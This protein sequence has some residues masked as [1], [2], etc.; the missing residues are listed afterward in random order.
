MR[1]MNSQRRHNSSTRIALPHSR[2]LIE[3]SAV[4]A[5]WFF[6]FFCFDFFFFFF[7]VGYTL[8]F[9]PENREG[10]KLVSNNKKKTLTRILR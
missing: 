6:F 10:D 4:T 3:S 1:K 5:V 9:R 2:Q 7:L 8:N